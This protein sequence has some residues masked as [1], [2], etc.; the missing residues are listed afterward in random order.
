MAKRIKAASTDKL[1]TFAAPVNMTA[2]PEEGKRPSFLIEAYTGVAMMAGGDF[3]NPIVVDLSGVQAAKSIPVLLDHDTTQIVGQ[4]EPSVSPEGIRIA[5]TVTG[6]SGPSASV[7]THAKNGFAWQASIGGNVGKR[8]FLDAGKRATV[9]GR[10]ITGPA[11]IA[12]EFHL[13]EVSFVAIG[14]DGATSA[15]VAATSGHERANTMSE[16]E[17][18]LVA[19]GFDA[20]TLNAAQTDY[21]KTL[22][23]SEQ[24]PADKVEAKPDF[25]SLDEVFAKSKAERQRREEISRICAEALRD[26]PHLADELELMA[27]KAIDGGVGPATF[28]L[29]VLRASRPYTKSTVS[30]SKPELSAQVIEAALCQSMKLA[31][32]EK[33]YDERTLEAA[34]RLYRGGI[35]LQ[36]FLLT[37][38]RENG[39]EEISLKSNGAIRNVLKAAFRDDSRNVK[40]S[41]F[42]TLSTPSILSNIANKFVVEAFNFVESSWRQITAIR[43]VSDFKTITNHSLTGDLQYEKIG[44]GGEIKHGTLGEQTYTNKAETYAKMLAITRQDIINDD[45]GAFAAVPRRLGRGAALKINDVFWT[46][47]LDNSTFFTSGRGNYDDGTDTA[48]TAAGMD[49]ALVFWNALTDPDGK[50]MG[51]T[52]RILLVP[53]GQWYKAQALMSSTNFNNGTTSNTADGNPFAGM[54]QVVMSR[55]LANSSYTGY[56]ALAWYLLADPMDVPVIETAFL[57]GREQPV[58]ETAD[59]DFDQL[60]IQMRGYHDF[61]V[62]LQE[63]RGGCKFKGEA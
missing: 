35:G 15:A 36:Q 63:Y 23:A 24:K 4:G 51:T 39:C 12:R 48:L 30:R 37:A 40:A 11:V 56:S 50:P 60:G 55:Y 3:R 14:A 59:A 58:V 33:K 7:V 8:E 25:A 47:F 54:F 32:V 27:K 44:A 31:D 19:K 29:D 34:D 46:E 42:S 53:P 22:F 18:W 20:A 16:F 5:G 6:D 13:R 17:K 49:A 52:P 62:N 41:G 57:G 1:V 38:A 2:S 26:V 28:E 61:G 43:N 10:E 45:L 21:F 9:N